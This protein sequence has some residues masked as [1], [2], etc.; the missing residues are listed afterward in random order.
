MGDQAVDHAGVDRGADRGALGDAVG[1]SDDARDLRKRRARGHDHAAALYLGEKTIE[2][3]LA[4]IYDKLGVH[5]RAALT[6]VI[7]REG[8]S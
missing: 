2:S 6:A 5:S 8:T 1:D 4:R 3:H 7:V